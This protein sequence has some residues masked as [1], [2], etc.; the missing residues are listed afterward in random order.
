MKEQSPVQLIEI[1]SRD[2]MRIEEKS[3]I[4]FDLEFSEKFG[5]FIRERDILTSS[6]CE[7]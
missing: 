1:I 4:W 3:K 2:F 7:A 5:I 6:C